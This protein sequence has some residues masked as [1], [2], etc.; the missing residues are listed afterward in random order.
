[1][2]FITIHFPSQL[3]RH[4]ILDRVEE[5]KTGDK[6]HPEWESTTGG[7]GGEVCASKQEG[8]SRFRGTRKERA[9]WIR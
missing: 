3:G 5:C 2:L 6:G 1:M 8:C 9:P 7:S 4:E